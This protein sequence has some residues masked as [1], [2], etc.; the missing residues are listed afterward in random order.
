MSP[1]CYKL[2]VCRLFFYGFFILWIIIW[3][4]RHTLYCRYKMRSF[5]NKQF[6][7]PSQV[8]RGRNDF[9]SSLIIIY[10]IAET[11]K[12]LRK[13]IITLHGKGW[14]TMWRPLSMDTSK[15]TRQF[16]GVTSVTRT[17]I[18]RILTNCIR[19]RLSCYRNWKKMTLIVA[20]IFRNQNWTNDELRNCF[21]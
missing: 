6:T 19:I 17:S 20:L 16:A 3:H 21:I 7:Y 8:P 5:G 11:L 12:S 4:I 18:R 13:T 1:L 9:G 10:M 14:R 2:H 15:G